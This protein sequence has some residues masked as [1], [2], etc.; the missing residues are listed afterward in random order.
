MP[1]IELPKAFLRQ[2]AR[3]SVELEPGDQIRFGRGTND[4]SFEHD[5]KQMRVYREKYFFGNW[6]IPRG[7]SGPEFALKIA[8]QFGL[9]LQSC[10]ET[11]GDPIWKL[12]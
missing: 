9:S 6:P 8:K 5:G 1:D 4:L 2:G 3:L 10:G 12:V 11:W 7:E